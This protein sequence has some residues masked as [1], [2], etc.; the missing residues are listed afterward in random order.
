MKAKITCV[1]VDDEPIALEL[2]KRYVERTPFLSLDAALTNG[3]E[4]LVYLEEHQ[5]DLIFLDIQMPDLNGLQLSKNLPPETKIVFTTAYDQYA[6]EGYKVSALDYLLKP[7]DYGEFLTAANKAKEWY[8]HHQ[9][10]EQSVAPV[11]IANNYIFVKSE[12]KTLKI[13][14]S[15]ILYLEGLKDYVK[16]YVEQQQ[17]PILTLLSMKKLESALPPSQFMRVH[18]S[19]IVSLSRID[20]VER[21]Q[22]LIH[23][24]RITVAEQYKDLFKAF[25]EGR[26]L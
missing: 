26:T 3:L 23:G 10:P 14:L 8:T 6:L 19:Y 4:V 24:I 5:P 12:Y 17:G 22:I 11:H 15:D 9:V 1:V 7:I 21:N 18:R 16:I 2:L 25:I 13:N 20:A